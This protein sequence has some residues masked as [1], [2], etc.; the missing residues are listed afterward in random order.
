MAA[1]LWSHEWR[2]S[3]ISYQLARYVASPNHE[4]NSRCVITLGI[5]SEVRDNGAHSFQTS[6]SRT[7]T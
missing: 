4:D 5:D 1:K 6:G 2:L 3:E 7:N